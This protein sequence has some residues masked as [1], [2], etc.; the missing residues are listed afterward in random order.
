MAERIVTSQDVQLWS[1]DFGDP[2]DPTLLLVAG[3]GLTAMSWPAE[4]VERLVAGGL[5]VIRYDHWGVGRSTAWDPAERPYSYLRLAADAVAVLDGW[6]VE[7]AHFV[8]MSMGTVLCQLVALD[9]PRRM[10]SM[11]MMLGGALD[12]DFPGNIRRAF[13]GEPPADGLPLPQER[14]L[15]A[16]AV[17]NEEVDGP[18]A[19]LDRRVRRWKLFSGDEAPFDEA[20]FR[21]WERQAVD[22][23]G[24]LTEPQVHYAVQP[25]PRERAAELRDVRVPTLVI[26]AGQDPIAPPPH[27]SHL[28]GL[29]PGA[30]LVE[31]GDMG[32]ALPRSVHPQLAEALLGHVRRCG[33]PWAATPTGARRRG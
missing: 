29:I 5:H 8:G 18:E 4:F 32:H 13:A 16:L 14:F 1:E 3:G 33:G 17:M 21:R 2:A 31:I 6:G 28:A 9:H 20:D 30:Y 24:S 7:R 23:S 10:L 27:G 19:E 26:Q 22:H 15:R 25:P 11:S 12:V